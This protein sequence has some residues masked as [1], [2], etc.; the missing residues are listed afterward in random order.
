MHSNNFQP[1]KSRWPHLYEH[2]R[3]AEQYV[4]SDP[5]TTTIKLRCFAESLVSFLYRELNLPS[6]TTEGLFEKLQAQVFRNVVDREIIYKL[7]AIRQQGNKAAHGG[8]IRAEDAL[9]LIKEAYL[10][11]QWLHKTYGS[12]DSDE[13]PLFVIPTESVDQLDKFNTAKEKLAEQLAAAKE[14]LARLVESEKAAQT[15]ITALNQTTDQS[16][17]DNFKSASV[18][19]A[20]TIDFQ[21]TNTQKL[22]SIQGAFAEYTLNDGQT[23]LIQKLGLFLS[24]NSE[25]VF[26]LKGYAGSGKTFITKGLTEYFRAI[27][28][29]YVLAAPTGKA[30][31]VIA[32]KTK[33]P[34]YTIHKTIYSFDDMVEYREEGVDGTETFKFYAQLIV[35]SLSADTVFI[36][37]E[38]S[39]VSDI[40][41]EAEF[42]R[43]GT[44]LLLTDFMKFV[45]LDHNDHKKK[46]IFIG[47]DAQ[48]PPIGMKLSPAL[49]ARYLEENYQ[50]RTIGFELT[51]V[52][53]QKADS[54]VIA[55]AAQVR[56]ALQYAQFN[57]L[58]VN[59]NYSD[60]EEVSYADLMPRYLESCGNKINKESIVIAYSNA[61]VA[62]YNSKIRAHFF[63]GHEQLEAGDK[64]MAVNNSTTGGL[65]ISNGDFGMIRKVFGNSEQ[66][67]ITLRRR[68]EIGEIEQ[69]Q[70]PL[71]FRD[72]EVGFRDLDGVPHYF[73]TKIVENLLYNHNSNLSSDQTKALYVDFCIRN[74]KLP[75]NS[76]E[77]KNTLKSDPYFTAMRL[78]FG[79]AITCHK[80][81][82]SEWKHVFVKCRSSQPQC[83]AHYFRWFYTAITRTAQYL[84]LLDPPNI[85]PPP[86]REVRNLG[87][88]INIEP[89]PILSDIQL[90]GRANTS[91]SQ[92]VANQDH[93]I[94]APF[95]LAVLNK[96]RQFVYDKNVEIESI[97]HDQNQEAYHFKR[98][99]E[100]ARINIIYTNKGH[101]SNVTALYQTNFSAELVN[102]LAPLKNCIFVIGDP[103]IDPEFDHEFLKIFH[104][105]I[106]HMCAER[107]INLWKVESL[108]NALRYKFTRNEEIAVFIVWYKDNGQFS[109]FQI[110]RN[111]CTPGNLVGEVRQMLTKGIK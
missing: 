16:K 6:E 61:D 92:N 79:Y 64:V 78:K 69:I 101:I 52:V 14:E 77:F 3:F 33:S 100:Y 15:K 38:A 50:V 34:A 43:F 21:T 93:G 28:R 104:L 87:E 40:Y 29:N 27:G 106:K 20:K 72:V 8:N 39:M 105:K 75:R 35:N 37:D 111:A 74:E 67:S 83:S 48:L 31:K 51:E 25:N 7:H 32:S 2:A 65:F 94:T 18:K 109:T 19:A 42:F 66:R 99:A 47:D 63:P 80:A 55:N 58:N 41:Q 81:Q 85:M 4:Y 91:Q 30:A 10:I 96:I 56:T 13:Y 45:N 11:G 90:N 82:G 24:G 102:A 46:I 23:E 88:E 108:Q 84:Y 76:V 86:I 73:N 26:I 44:G 5:Q 36:V 12:D 71:I 60:V 57:K 59:F 110:Q 98:G 89:V 22:I 62:D 1:L 53:R 17:L 70:V 103:D 95:L 49:D 54:G 9:L 107:G 97:Q 68:N